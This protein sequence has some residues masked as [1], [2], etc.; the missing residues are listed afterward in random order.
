MFEFPDSKSCLCV[1]V[2]TDIIRNGKKNI[3]KTD[4]NGYYTIPVMALKKISS[5]NTYYDTPSF[6]TIISDEK[7]NFKDRLTSGCLY[8]EWGHPDL[9]QYKDKRESFQR[10][11]K[12]DEDR[13]SHH[14]KSLSVED[15]VVEAS[16]RPYGPYGSYLEDSFNTPT[17]NTAF[18]LRSLTKDTRMKSPETDKDVIYKNLVHLTT[19]DCV[20]NPGFKEATKM[21]AKSLEDLDGIFID[22]ENDNLSW[23]I[24]LENINDGLINDLFSTNEIIKIKQSLTIKNPKISD[25]LMN[26]A[27]FNY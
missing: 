23:N 3:L 17:I 5:N 27:S 25:M 9:S 10:L 20:L 21:F 2:E 15:D 16:I 22:K 1:T 26:N 8:G 18:S 12:V 19:F 4:S 7:S 24:S 11:I 6:S 13:V 14:I